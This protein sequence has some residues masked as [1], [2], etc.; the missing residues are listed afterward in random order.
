MNIIFPKYTTQEICSSITALL[1]NG[2]LITLSPVLRNWCIGG[3]G[4]ASNSTVSKKPVGLTISPNIDQNS[5]NTNLTTYLIG[6]SGGTRSYSP[7]FTMMFNPYV[8]PS[9]YGIV[10]GR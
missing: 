7:K 4:C 6:L 10:N 8:N 1:K 9:P 3:Y 2:I 5:S